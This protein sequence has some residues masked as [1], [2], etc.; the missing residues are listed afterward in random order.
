MRALTASG[1][2]GTITDLERGGKRATIEAGG[3][4]LTVATA[5][6][7]SPGTVLD[8]D[9][10]DDPR[11]GGKRRRAAAGAAPR[12]GRRGDFGAGDDPPLHTATPDGAPPQV[13]R[14]AWGGDAPARRS[15]PASLDL[16]GA[17]M[18]E[19]VELLEQYLDQAATARAGRVTVIHGH[20]SG[21]LRDA[22]RNTLTGH[23]LVQDWRPGERGEGGDGATIVTL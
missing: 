18:E 14:S 2:E 15:I 23:P 5:E 12:D 10:A 21:A 13:T 19:A 1:F 11:G 3:M 22:V 7:F 8:T 6:L 17:R 16:R 4:R 20:G 9:G